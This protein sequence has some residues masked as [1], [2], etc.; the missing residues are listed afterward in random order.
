MNRAR[1]LA[2]EQLEPRAVSKSRSMIVGRVHGLTRLQV[3]RSRTEHRIRGG[4]CSAALRCASCPRRTPWYLQ[5]QAFCSPAAATPTT[6]A[7][8]PLLENVT[9]VAQACMEEDAGLVV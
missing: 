1:V 9:V 2:N 4:R 6:W 5:S 7:G 3:E 8:G